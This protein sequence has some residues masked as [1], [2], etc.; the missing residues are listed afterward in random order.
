[1]PTDLGSSPVDLVNFNGVPFGRPTLVVDSD[2]GA[3]ASFQG[4]SAPGHFSAGAALDGL[5]AFSV[6]LA[7]QPDQLKAKHI[8]MNCN[9]PAQP[10][11]GDAMGI[12]LVDNGA[13]GLTPRVY[14]WTGSAPLI[15]K[16]AGGVIFPS[17]SIAFLTVVFLS[18]GTFNVYVNDQL[19]GMQITSGTS[20][21]SWPAFSSSSTCR[22][23][24]YQD[25]GS[26]PFQG[27]MAEVCVFSPPLSGSKIAQ[28]FGAARHTGQAVYLEAFDVG[29]LSGTGSIDPAAVAATNPKE[30][31]TAI[32]DSDPGGIVT[33]VG[34]Q[35]DYDVTA[36]PDGPISFDGSISKAGV[37]SAVATISATV[38]A[39]P[40]PGTALS[41]GSLSV[42]TPLRVRVTTLAGWPAGVTPAEVIQQGQFAKGVIRRAWKDTQNDGTY[43]DFY[44]GWQNTALA[45]DSVKVRLSDDSV[46]DIEYDVIDP[47]PAGTKRYLDASKTTNGDGTSAASAWNT[48]AA[49][50]AGVQAGQVLVVSAKTG[51]RTINSVSV[52]NYVYWVDQDTGGPSSSVN[53]VTVIA[54]PADT[55]DGRRPTIAIWGNRFGP[56]LNASNNGEW[57]LHADLGSHGSVWKT[58][59]TFSSPLQGYSC[60]YRSQSGRW[61]K[62]YAL[63]CINATTSTTIELRLTQMSD[64]TYPRFQYQNHTTYMGPSITYETDGHYYIRLSPTRE[65]TIFNPAV[66]TGP[67]P[68]WD[69]SGSYPPSENPNN[70]SISIV[71]GGANSTRNY[72]LDLTGRTGWTFQNVDLTCGVAG[73]ITKNA[74]NL[75]FYGVTFKGGSPPQMT[76]DGGLS[77][78]YHFLDSSGS[79]AARSVGFIF[80]HCEIWGQDPP[81]FS[82]LEGKGSQGG[83]V[84][85]RGDLDHGNYLNMVIRHSIIDGFWV[86]SWGGA[87]DKMHIHHSII[88]DYGHDGGVSGLP[89]GDWAFIRSLVTNACP[90]A[91]SAVGARSQDH[92]YFGLNL[93]LNIATLVCDN[94][95]LPLQGKYAFIGN[96]SSNHG[97]D[98][99]VSATT[100]VIYHGGYELFQEWKYNNTAI[101]TN[102]HFNPRGDSPLGPAA[103][104]VAS[105]G[106]HR[107]LNC[108]G[109]IVPGP[110]KW[111]AGQGQMVARYFDQ[112]A[113]VYDYNCLWRA[114][115]GWPTK[116]T[117]NDVCVGLV[118]IEGGS[119]TVCATTIDALRARGMEAHGINA[120]PQFVVTPSWASSNPLAAGGNYDYANYMLKAGSPARTGG[121][122]LASY[123]FADYDGNTQTIWR[124]LNGFRGALDPNVP[125]LEQEIGPMG[126][127]P[128]GK[129]FHS[130]SAA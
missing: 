97:T 17:A 104:T 36:E 60:A 64:T 40:P 74:D 71:T 89:R 34:G 16:G 6:H 52:P 128:S 10:A 29:T 62:T 9:D 67:F 53:N 23:G 123:S 18:D 85:M 59:R 31:L 15:A 26:A 68:Q 72:L 65:Q 118:R 44:P 48:W 88:N 110:W 77:Y 86:F 46:V 32:E 14:R 49:A 99:P 120:D 51:S 101:G 38:A 30:G 83:G 78:I 94:G 55:A 57:T 66:Y 70:V 1:M 42:F 114:L 82:W 69:W 13:G 109:M 90:W 12:E 96:P 108:I 125:M 50:M 41:L 33:P 107:V 8:L 102:H 127:L 80:D 93:L 98:V 45:V 43:M 105:L 121:A 75:S 5:T 129:I 122:N 3:S 73:L 126:P 124:N 76:E 92:A 24:V 103:S 81:W 2:G 112:A 115:S 20:A 63:R 113:A 21:G 7:V 22:L 79:T 37:T 100:N 119:S 106:A 56:L 111:S 25:G 91:W 11:S 130:G 28:L 87:W 58:V 4:G 95:G 39:A 27:L 117:G 35:W 61:I 47:L 116:G 54:D 84:T 19:V